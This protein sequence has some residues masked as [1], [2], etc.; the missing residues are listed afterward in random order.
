MLPDILLHGVSLG[1]EYLS[2]GAA[3]ALGCTNRKFVQVAEGSRPGQQGKDVGKLQHGIEIG[4]GGGRDSGA[5]KGWGGEV[6]RSCDLGMHS[7][8]HC[9]PWDIIHLHLAAPGRTPWA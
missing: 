8:C 6:G 5:G 4:R 7:F 1:L 9:K 2:G 3:D